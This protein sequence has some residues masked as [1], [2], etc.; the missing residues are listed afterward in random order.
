[1]KKLSIKAKLILSFAAVL[2][3]INILGA[4]ALYSMGNIQQK[5]DDIAIDCMDGL[6]DAQS[7]IDR[8]Y[9]ARSYEL[10]AI[11]HVDPEKIRQD[12]DARAENALLIEPIFD[13]YVET[14]KG[15][16]Y[17]SEEDRATDMG[18]IEEIM[19]GWR[20]YQQASEQAITLRQRGLGAEARAILDGQSLQAFERLL[21][22]GETMKQ[23]NKDQADSSADE[24][25]QIYDW[26][27]M[28]SIVIQAAS[29]II[30]I[31][32]CYMLYRHIRL[33]IEELARVSEAIGKGRLDCFV[34]IYRE[35]ELG[36]LSMQYN[37]T[38][39]QI[40]NLITHLQDT[41]EQLVAASENINAHYGQSAGT[42]LTITEKAE[43]ISGQ[44]SEQVVSIDNVRNIV[45][46][47]AGKIGAAAD[48]AADSADGAEMAIKKSQEG[49]RSITLAAKQMKEIEGAVN[50]T[51]A[52]MET[53]GARSHEISD[54][55]EAISA[56]SSQTNLLALNA[57]IEA[58]RAGENGRGFSVVA[59]EVRKL[60]EQSQTATE[61]IAGLI[62]QVQAETRQAVESMKT[63]VA[64]VGRG[65]E[66]VRESGEAFRQLADMSQGI[67]VHVREIAGKMR[68][69]TEKTRDIIKVVGEVYDLSNYI[70]K[71]TREAVLAL[72][73]QSESVKDIA[74]ASGNLSQLA[75]N[76]RQNAHKFTI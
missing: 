58:A 73:E 69:V 44:A 18:Y 14:I 17:D 24:C 48:L 25:R 61:K 56:I 36:T 16:I 45:A 53:L 33:P 68:E 2:V 41:A 5:I 62:Q 64:E 74:A 7:I 26:N 9:I 32:L 35:D 23:F 19:A 12:L 76:M 37:S 70:S 43:K 50:N 38:I 72:E 42:A 63:G 75:E 54:I 21:K 3:L 15:A 59:D 47:V 30:T 60:A 4:Y 29:L 55:V 34:K 66:I 65:G 51:A 10:S 49:A 20:E 1:M 57:A 22:A 27:K 13:S 28:V 39:A 67:G 31:V 8:T 6:V 46:D 52:M 11:A 71:D 40:R